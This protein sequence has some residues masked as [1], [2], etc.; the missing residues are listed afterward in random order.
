[1]VGDSVGLNPDGAL[2]AL[3]F[4]ETNPN[5]NVQTMTKQLLFSLFITF[6]LLG[7]SLADRYLIPSTVS[8]EASAVLKPIYAGVKANA[9]TPMERPA[10]LAEFEAMRAPSE[11]AAVAGLE[12]LA[13]ELGVTVSE[14]TINSIE[15]LRIKPAA[16]ALR[17]G[18]LVYLHGGAYAMGSIRQNLIMPAKLA[19][20]SGYEVISVEYT[21]AP[22]AKWQ[23]TTAEVLKVWSGLLE[24]GYA[25][26]AI[27]IFGDSAG[28]GLAA[29]SVL[30]MRDEGLA[31]PGALYLM[32]P[33]A[34]ITVSGDTMVTLAEFDPLIPVGDVEWVSALYAAPNEQRHPYVSPVYGDYSKGFPPTL[35]QVGTR[36]VLL[37][38]SVR[39]YQAVRSG[40]ANAVLD[41]YDGMPHVFQG[42]V[43]DSPEGRTATQ[44][45]VEFFHEH[46]V[47]K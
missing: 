40:G 4:H 16:G 28:G 24:L 2:P 41:V 37:S 5:D 32:S 33:W 1:M 26:D 27:G 15:T 11:A 30:R 44:R 8:E 6:T 13:R 12:K 45:A 46:L 14:Q 47:G 36:E 22:A 10:T 31:M 18:V 9:G 34:D 3:N 43:P 39:L 35:I 42:F 25:A 21:L 19:T 7:H 29:G 20:A 23:Q 17:K 38:A